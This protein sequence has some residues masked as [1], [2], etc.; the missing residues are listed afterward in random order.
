MRDE[1]IEE[2]KNVYEQY[3]YLRDIYY[4]FL[5]S[6]VAE[7]YSNNGNNYFKMAASA[8]IDSYI[9]TL[10]RLFDTNNK[11]SGIMNL[12]NKC[13]QNSDL[14]N[15]PNYIFIELTEIE[16]CLKRDKGLKNTIEIIRQRRNHYHAHNDS[17]YFSHT[18]ENDKAIQDKTY[19][20]AHDIWSLINFVKDLLDLL[21]KELSIDLCMKMQPKYDRDLAELLPIIQERQICPLK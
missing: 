21:I 2:I 14:F 7:E 16:R 20:P 18:T 6:S 17:N 12:I 11:S 9:M 1:I 15:D 8:C 10:A 4:V 3:L 19:L 13:K 5:D